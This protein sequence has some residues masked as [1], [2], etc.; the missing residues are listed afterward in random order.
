MPVQFSSYLIVVAFTIA[1]H[2]GL[3]RNTDLQIKFK[4]EQRLRQRFF[5]CV[6]A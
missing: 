2:S 5:F 1:V 6:A 3:T 4:V